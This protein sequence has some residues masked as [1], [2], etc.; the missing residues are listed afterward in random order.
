[1]KTILAYGCIFLHALFLNPSAQADSF[2]IDRDYYPTAT[3]DKLH[4]AFVNYEKYSSQNGANYTQNFKQ[5]AD[6]LH[7]SIP[8]FGFDQIEVHLLKMY[9][10]KVMGWISPTP[11]LDVPS[12]PRD[13]R[14][15]VVVALQPSTLTDLKYYPKFILDCTVSPLNRGFQQICKI[16]EPGE[17]TLNNGKKIKPA[18]I[19]NG[20]KQL[21]ST[22][23]VTQT[24]SGTHVHVHIEVETNPAEITTIKNAVKAD[25]ESI[26]LI[27][28]YLSSNID[29]LF[30]EQTFFTDYYDQ[31]YESW[32]KSI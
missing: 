9:Y 8:S 10:S 11:E 2:P 16:M 3:L 19:T 32:I 21:T 20:L 17:Y 28:G 15:L 22:T 6:K 25:Y 7:I 14:A 26:P 5:L 30:S 29:S 13:S 24:G 4:Q 23:T 27:G 18:R 31:Y 1:M 12:S